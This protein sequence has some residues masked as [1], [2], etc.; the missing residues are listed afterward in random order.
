MVRSATAAM[1]MGT[2]KKTTIFETIIST[3]KNSIISQINESI[4]ENTLQ[5]GSSLQKTTN[6]ATTEMEPLKNQKKENVRKTKN[7]I[8]Q[9]KIAK[10]LFVLEHQKIINVRICFVINREEKIATVKS[11]IYKIAD[12]S[13]DVPPRIRRDEPLKKAA[14]WASSNARQRRNVPVL[15]MIENYVKSM[16]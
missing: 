6:R 10:I 9:N 11:N 14:A 7:T 5:K 4:N 13:I 12:S 3:T 16:V 8:K 1:V 15:C 2:A